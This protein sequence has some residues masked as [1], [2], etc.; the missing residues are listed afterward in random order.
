MRRLHRVLFLAAL[1][2]SVALAT[3]GCG[4]P[5]LTEED[6]GEVIDHLPEVPGA[7]KPYKLPEFEAVPPTDP[8]PEP[9]K[10]MR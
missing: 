7:E 1:F 8:G 10:P 3:A 2:G 9:K 5:R 4:G 6:L